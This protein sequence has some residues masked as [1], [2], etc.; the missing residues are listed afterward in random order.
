MSLKPGF[1]VRYVSAS[2]SS[3]AICHEVTQNIVA[4][5][6]EWNVDSFNRSLNIFHRCFAESNHSCSAVRHSSR[7]L[8][9]PAS[10]QCLCAPGPLF[11]T[12]IA[13][14]TLN[15]W[16]RV[17]SEAPRCAQ[18][19]GGRWLLLVSVYVNPSANLSCNYSYAIY[20]YNKA[21]GLHSI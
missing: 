12:W 7:F 21:T 8:P 20:L 10:H 11:Q 13:Y 6:V 14:Y 15:A 17:R 9:L 1:R 19:Y 2:R 5:Q 3:R 4:H 18:T 16:C